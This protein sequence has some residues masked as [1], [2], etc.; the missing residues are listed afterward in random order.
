MLTRCIRTLAV[1]ALFAAGAANAEI[2][3]PAVWYSARIDYSCDGQASS[4][5]ISEPSPT[6]CQYYLNQELMDVNNAGCD[7]VD[8]DPCRFHFH[9][10]SSSVSGANSLPFELATDFG[11]GETELRQRFRI[12]EY[13]AE[14]GKLLQRLQPRR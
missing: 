5:I 13:E 11:N 1:A 7:L 4:R 3:G 6:L 8:L 9:G 2:A 14:M 12:D 10:F